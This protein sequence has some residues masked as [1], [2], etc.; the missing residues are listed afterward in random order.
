[1]I[2]NREDY[3]VSE[4]RINDLGYE[5]MNLDRVDDAIKVF[6]CNNQLF[7]ES[8]NSF[9]SLA[10][11]YAAAGD[12]DLA[13]RYYEHALKIDPELQSAIE[14]LKKLKRK[15]GVGPL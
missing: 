9:D 2:E 3:M 1:M 12:N 8:A 15:F 14:A 4:R 6:H 10:E 11:A 7:P 13:I 5:L